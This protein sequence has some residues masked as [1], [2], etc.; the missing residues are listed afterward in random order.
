[1]FHRCSSFR[2]C[3]IKPGEYFWEIL[4]NGEDRRRLGGEELSNESKL[5][6]GMEVLGVPD[7]N[8][9]NLEWKSFLW[10]DVFQMPWKAWD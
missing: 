10:A 4:E 9:H 2:A 7:V 3:V 8:Q 5:Q 1:M 6:T